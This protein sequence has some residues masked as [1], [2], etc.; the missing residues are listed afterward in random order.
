[1]ND[2][3]NIP[4]TT[5][6]Y[7]SDSIDYDQ[8][9]TSDDHEGYL[10]GNR[11]YEDDLHHGGYYSQTQAGGHEDKEDKVSLKGLQVVL[12]S[13]DC[14]DEEVEEEECQPCHLSEEDVDSFIPDRWT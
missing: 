2:D 4:R 14:T 9:E 12:L 8:L 7:R 3:A 5:N 1:M 10:V 6:A 11:Y 13:L